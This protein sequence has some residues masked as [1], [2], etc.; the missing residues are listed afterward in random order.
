ML[1]P[2][3]SMVFAGCLLGATTACVPIERDQAKEQRRASTAPDANR[4]VSPKP[5]APDDPPLNGPFADA[6]ERARLGPDWLATADTW[7]LQDGRL[8]VENAHNHPVWLKRRLPTNATIEFTA[9][10]A[11]AEGDIKAEAWGDGRS[12]PQR[13]AYRNATSYLIV[14]GG[15]RNRFHVLARKDEHARDRPEIAIQPGG[16]PNA[17]AVVPGQAYRIKIERSDGKTVKWYVDGVEILSYVD[18]VP[19]TGPGHD[20]FAFNDWTT[21]VCFDDLKITPLNTD[22]PVRD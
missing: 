20:H 10:S 15:W 4:D 14:F 11:S 16:P 3:K 2:T 7:R 17:R 6:F 12:A 5:A 9:T 21:P 8:C 19:L 22:G 1:I 13:A 18:A